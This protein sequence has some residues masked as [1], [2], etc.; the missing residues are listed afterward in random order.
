MLKSWTEPTHSAETNTQLEQRMPQLT[1]TLSRQ[2]FFRYIHWM[3]YSETAKR[4]RKNNETQKNDEWL[5]MLI[6]IEPKESTIR[7]IFTINEGEWRR[8]VKLNIYSRYNK[9]WLK[10]LNK[11]N[12]KIK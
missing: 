2:F 1:H 11:K 6:E 9:V 8:K 7:T 3:K 12:K 5:M 4:E 10:I